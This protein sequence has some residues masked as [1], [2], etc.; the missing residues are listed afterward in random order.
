VKLLMQFKTT[1]T[2]NLTLLGMS[3]ERKTLF[4]VPFLKKEI[5][6]FQKR[7]RYETDSKLK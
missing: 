3:T 2:D 6:S 1:Q 7:S 4:I 5:T